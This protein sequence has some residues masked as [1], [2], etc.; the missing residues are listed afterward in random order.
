MPVAHPGAAARLVEAPERQHEMHEPEPGRARATRRDLRMRLTDDLRSEL[1]AFQGFI[2]TALGPRARV[3][4]D[5]EGW[6][7]VPARYGN[8]HWRGREWGTGEARVWAFADRARLVSKLLAVP[9]VH[10]WQTGDDEAAAW[11]AAADVDTIRTVAGLL[12]TRIRREAS[13]GNAAA[14]ARARKL[15]T[16]P[17]RIG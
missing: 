15:Q 7:L 3:T 12:R 2:L 5:P 14:L 11:I 17:A 1:H 6:P 8:L 13:T 10:R 16:E 9:G 4:R